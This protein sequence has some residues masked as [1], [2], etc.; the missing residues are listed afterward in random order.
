VKD[1]LTVTDGLTDA[2]W[3]GDLV[4]LAV[5]EDDTLGVSAG[6]PDGDTEAL[7]EVDRV[8]DGDTDGDTEGDFAG[9]VD[10]DPLELVD[11]EVVGERL[12][13]TS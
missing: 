6:E 3:L 9:D 1:G 8:V 10:E 11:G 2:L 5:L 4:S 13:Q 12:A 7:R